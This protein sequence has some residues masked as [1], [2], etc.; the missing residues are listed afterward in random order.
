MSRH[1][2]QRLPSRLRRTLIACGAVAAA[3]SLL[4]AAMNS[5]TLL[6]INSVLSQAQRALPK[7]E[8]AAELYIQARKATSAR[9]KKMLF[10]Q[11]K[12]PEKKN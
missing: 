10:P 3:F 8:E 2:I 6:R 9:E 5:L 1:S 12:S 4:S 11:A 7:M